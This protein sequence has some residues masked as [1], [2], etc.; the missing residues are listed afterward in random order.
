MRRIELGVRG[1]APWRSIGA[2]TRASSPPRCQSHAQFLR[3]RP[4]PPPQGWA[5]LQVQAPAFVREIDADWMS[6]YI[7]QEYAAACKTYGT[8]AEHRLDVEQDQHAWLH[9]MGDSPFYRRAAM[10]WED[11]QQSLAVA[12]TNG[13]RRASATQRLQLDVAPWRSNVPGALC[14]AIRTL[15][16]PGRLDRMRRWLRGALHG[17]VHAQP[18]SVRGR[19]HG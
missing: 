1:A 3:G 11:A 7:V 18:A 2:C 13:A 15:C 6:N 12:T 14:S 8:A 5:A 9:I 10:E 19:R 17:A 16:L 4:E